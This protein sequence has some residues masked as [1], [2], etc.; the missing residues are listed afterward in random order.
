MKNK[1]ICIAH[2]RVTILCT[3]TQISLLLSFSDLVVFFFS[4]LLQRA[5]FR[6]FLPFR[7]LFLSLFLSLW[8]SKSVSGFVGSSLTDRI[9]LNDYDRSCC[10]SILHYNAI[11]RTLTLVNLLGKNALAIISSRYILRLLD[12]R[13]EYE[14]TIGKKSSK[15]TT[16]YIR[17]HTCADCQSLFSDT[18]QI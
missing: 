16:L 8:Y 10:K 13:L 15:P 5:D 18:V 6:F 17:Q 9:V 4:F 7:S 14:F 3:R 2:S 11:G 12:A 1:S